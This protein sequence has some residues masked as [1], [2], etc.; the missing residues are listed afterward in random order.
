MKTIAV[1]G[2]GITGITTAYAL[3]KRGFAVTLFEKHR[4]AAMET[5]F[6][7]GG[8]LSASNAEVWN[9]WSTIVKG[10]K[11]M[12][13]S[14]APLLVNPKP[15]WHKLSW[16]AEFIA[17]IPSYNQNTIETARL[18]VA[19]R[20]HLFA[21]AEAEGIDFDLK[22]KGILHIYRDKAGFDH[23]G[24][25]SQLLAKG[26]LP[27]RSVTP[28][29]MRSIEPTLA[30]QYYGGY[31]T[32]CDSTG[33][34]HKFTNGL[35]AAIDRLGVRC[36]YNQDVKAVTTDGKRA[37]VTTGSNAGDE[38]QH[39]DGVVV[40]AGTAS[41]DLAAQLGDR[42]NI[43]PVKGYSITVNLTDE[44]S[45]ASAP[46][47]SL[48]DDE[49][50]LVTSRL[51]NDRFR[52]AGTAEFNGYNRDIRADRI[53]PLVD[54]VNECFPGVNTRSVVPWAG[55]RPMMPNMMPKVGR[56]KS[57][58]VFY[59]TGHGHLG[60]TLSAVTADMIGGVVEQALGSNAKAASPQPAHA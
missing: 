42:V 18:A 36:L 40:C 9:H 59:N 37:S 60:W 5:S 13:K 11:W 2:G 47:V 25:V 16:F 45:R 54:W 14:D 10:L 19:A 34:I 6:A 57:P 35:A 50:K 15:S 8:Q 29:E 1:V 32:E 56:G 53:R 21:W 12:L 27:R 26:G 39:F 55:L 58:C 48:L 30:G 7:N 24:R 49:T 20:E 46:T 52:V 23:A 51:G 17:S 38:T 33:D 4:Y 28:E 44:I 22:K 31:F 41:R 43:Y 3:S